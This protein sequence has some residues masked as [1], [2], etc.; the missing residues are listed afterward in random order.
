MTT[1]SQGHLLLLLLLLLQH[2]QQQQSRKIH[3]Q[4]SEETVAVVNSSWQRWIINNGSKRRNC[5]RCCF[6]TL[7]WS[8]S[9]LSLWLETLCLF[10]P[11]L[12]N[13][14]KCHF[15][16]NT[17]FE[18]ALDPPTPPILS[19]SAA[20]PSTSLSCFH[21]YC[22]FV[23]S[24]IERENARAWV[25]LR[26]RERAV[27]PLWILCSRPRKACGDG[28]YSSSSTSCFRRRRKYCTSPWEKQREREKE[29]VSLSLSLSLFLSFFLYLSQTS[30]ERVGG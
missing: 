8:S 14:L 25:W 22:F 16:Y 11:R 17:L 29:F 12:A 4:Q 1:V 3:R 30:T 21:K 9:F 10:L 2:Q 28:D 19:E 18:S 23:R 20:T 6:L 5:S 13:S 24:Y 26:K 7:N 15:P 27:I